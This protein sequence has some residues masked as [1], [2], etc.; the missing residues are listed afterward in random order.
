[1][2]AEPVGKRRE[3][4]SSPSP[5]PSP[6]NDSCQSHPHTATLVSNTIEH[7]KPRGRPQAGNLAS[8]N[9]HGCEVLYAVKMRPPLWRSSRVVSV[10]HCNKSK[11]HLQTLSF[12]VVGSM[13][14][15]VGPQ[16]GRT[17]ACTPCI[18]TPYILKPYLRSSLRCPPL[19]TYVAFP[20]T[21]AT[22]RG[23]TLLPCC[24]RHISV[25]RR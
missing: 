12:F 18:T 20:T 10:N 15:T 11:D 14:P 17:R 5:G 21:S 9:D 23:N 4:A 16:H 19:A 7:L 13:S 24:T 6:P 8:A 22:T 3:T 25:V 1:M 2:Y